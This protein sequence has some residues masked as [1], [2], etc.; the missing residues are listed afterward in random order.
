MNATG[1]VTRSSRDRGQAPFDRLWKRIAPLVPKSSRDLGKGLIRA[2]GRVT[3][4]ARPLPDYLIIGTRRGGTTSLAKYLRAHPAVVPTPIFIKGVRFFDENFSAV[5][6]N[7]IGSVEV[8]S[9][10]DFFLTVLRQELRTFQL[11]AIPAT[12][13]R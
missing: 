13:I 9:T 4:W 11:T 2:T 5:P 10:T 7:F 8:Q 6:E 3:W 12:I 1:R